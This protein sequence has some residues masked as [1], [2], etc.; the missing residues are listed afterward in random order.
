[1]EAYRNIIGFIINCDDNLNGVVR[2]SEL[3]TELWLQRFKMNHH[4]SIWSVPEDFYIYI[5]AFLANSDIPDN[6]FQIAQEMIAEYGDVSPAIIKHRGNEITIYTQEPIKIPYFQAQYRFSEQMELPNTY[7]LR[8][9]AILILFSEYGAYNMCEWT[10][11]DLREIREL[12]D[13][14]GVEYLGIE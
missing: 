9:L 10:K 4:Y 5:W 11:D 2:Y 13:Y 14:F 1:M 7:E 12:L 8:H 3:L 6:M